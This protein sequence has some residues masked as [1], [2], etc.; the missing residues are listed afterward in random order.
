MGLA[1]MQEEPFNVIDSKQVM[2]IGLSVS[3]FRSK[4]LIS[5]PS[6]GVLYI[7][8]ANKGQLVF[9]TTFNEL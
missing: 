4:R 7:P 1:S 2:A 5:R 3:N 9:T 8:E 6:L